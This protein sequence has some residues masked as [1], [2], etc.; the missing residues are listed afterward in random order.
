VGVAPAAGPPPEV[1]GPSLAAAVAQ[2]GLELDLPAR[3]RAARAPPD[4]ARAA[5]VGGGVPYVAF[6][7]ALLADGS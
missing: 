6:R 3:L 1:G 4:M 5:A 2:A 7:A